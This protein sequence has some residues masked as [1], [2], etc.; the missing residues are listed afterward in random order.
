MNLQPTDV[1]FY[2]KNGY[3][4]L[5]GVLCSSELEQL[6][7][8][9]DRFLKFATTHRV[10]QGDYTYAEDKAGQVV[11]KRVNLL[12]KRMVEFQ[13][14]YGNP[15]ILEACEKLIGNSFIVLDDALIV[16]MPRNGSA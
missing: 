3:L 12:S 14:L 8:A 1:E 2:N 6:R 11:W 16:K 13:A 10:P 15:P 5:K 7:K 9:S 4:H